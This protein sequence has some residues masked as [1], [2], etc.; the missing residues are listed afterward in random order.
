VTHAPDSLVPFVALLRGINVGGRNKVPM[1]DLRR[2][3]A[4]R[5]L[6]DVRTHIAS[7]NVVALAPD[8]PEARD[9][10]A[11]AVTA[12]IAEDFGFDC[13]VLVRRGTEIQRIAE[14]IPEEWVNDGTRKADVLFLFD[15]V[16]SPDI[17]ERLPLV[18]DVDTAHYT[19]GAVLWSV[20]RAQQPR[21]G[22]PAIIGT[23]LYQRLTIRNVNTTRTLASMVGP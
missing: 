6:V 11:A 17:L 8:R 12:T 3:L 13:S 9:Q 15:D 16:D 5:G 20:T 14:A 19:P 10:V 1:A 7:G 23:P 2:G 22:M 21:S 4:G 18:P